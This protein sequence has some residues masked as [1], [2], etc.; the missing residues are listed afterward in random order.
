MA[1][2][3]PKI[4]FCAELTGWLEKARVY[5]VGPYKLVA[6][7]SVPYGRVFRY[8]DTKG[9][10][11]AYVNRGQIADLPRMPRARVPLVLDSTLCGIPIEV[12]P[13]PETE[14]SDG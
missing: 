6:H 9:R 2:G 8:Y 13:A 4:D 12:E 1:E 10:L 3:L 11:V 5:P 14:G 7:H